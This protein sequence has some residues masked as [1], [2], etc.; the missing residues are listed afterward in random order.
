MN[1]KNQLME[2]IIMHENYMPTELDLFIILFHY[3]ISSIKVSTNK[4]FVMAFINYVK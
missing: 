1:K 3:N 2:E 4:G